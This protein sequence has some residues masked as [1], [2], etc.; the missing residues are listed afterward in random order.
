MS[1]WA[2]ELSIRGLEAA[3]VAAWRELAAQAVD[4]NPF[5]E[6]DFLLPANRHVGGAPD[7]LLVVGDGDRW[8]ACL[9]LTRSRWHRVLALPYAGDPAYGFLATPLIARDGAERSSARLVDAVRERAP[10]V[11]QR[12]GVGGPFQAALAAAIEAGRLSALEEDRCERA[13]LLR[14]Q[15]DRLGHLSPHHRRD[16]RRMARRLAEDLGGP[17]STRDRAGEPAAVELFLE[18]E[19][20]GWKGRAH[21]A[22]ASDRSHAEFFREL[23]ANFARGGRLQLLEL[24]TAERP[25]AMKCN[26]LAAEGLFGFKIAFDESFARWSPGIQL[27]VENMN[28]FDR[29]EMAWMD[30]CADP[31]NA[32]INR[33]WPERLQLTTIVLGSGRLR[34]REAAALAISR[35]SGSQLRQRL[36]RSAVAEG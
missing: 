8:E 17:L 1:L 13:L 22:L 28:L 16:L 7:R 4:P 23:C 24:G 29:T 3:E 14:S 32:M 15:E 6:P 11:I 20:S 33:L 19:L 18:L 25:V 26:I 31:A 10:L 9:P 36:R 27:E 2:G 5:F 21:T 34:P 30:S 35:V 12:L